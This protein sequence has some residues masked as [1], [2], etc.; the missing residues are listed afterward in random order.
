MS[1]YD[2]FIYVSRKVEKSVYNIAA[3]FALNVPKTE[4]RMES[5]GSLQRTFP[6]RVASL[7]SINITVLM[8]A[9]KNITLKY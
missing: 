5:V 2:Q 8:I 6:W 7:N 4:V 9:L 3:V 1:F